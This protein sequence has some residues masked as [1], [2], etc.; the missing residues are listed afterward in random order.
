MKVTQEKL[1]ASQIGLEIEISEEK[2]KNTYEKVVKNLARSVNIPGFRKGKVPRHVLLQRLGVQSVKAAVLQELIEEILPQ[3]IEQ[4]S[5]EVL[6]NYQLRSN[7]EEL[8]AQYEPGKTIVFSAVVDVPPTVTLGDYLNLSVKAEETAYDAE[9]VENYLEKRRESQ[10]TLVPVENRPAQMGDVAVI[11]YQGRAVNEQGEQGEELPGTGGTDFL[12][13][14]SQGKLITGFVEGI[15][16]M[17]PGETREVPVTFPEDYPMKELAGKPAV[18]TITVK[19][20]KTKELPE[21][22]DDFAQ[23]VS[24]FETMAQL[25]QSLEEQF[26]KKAESETRNTIHGAIVEELLKQSVVELPETMVLDEVQTLITQTAMQMQNYGM[27]IKQIFNAESLPQM[28]E[29]TRPEAIQNL[30]TSLVLKEIAKKESIELERS[31]IEAKIEEVTKQ[32]GDRNI[33]Q[34]RLK[35]M[36][37]DDLLTE[38]TLNW[39]QSKTQVELVPK[40]TLTEVSSEEESQEKGE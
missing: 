29:R 22:D 8:V 34:Q 38:K 23:E 32:I 5:L 27:D 18:F 11:D 12:V 15:L 21:L 13:E 16:G 9:E 31:A 36:V 33:D 25:R 19:E 1:P 20:L 26:R 7:F 37:E 6:G 3:V 39:L 17:N 24:E 30:K 28:R 40:G 14:L 4:E 10:S 2:T 35:Q